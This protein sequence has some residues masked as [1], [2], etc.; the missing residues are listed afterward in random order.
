MKLTKYLLKVL[1]I[2]NFG[3]FKWSDYLFVFIQIIV[4]YP[5]LLQQKG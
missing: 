1:V 2:Q 3:S 5:I 4:N